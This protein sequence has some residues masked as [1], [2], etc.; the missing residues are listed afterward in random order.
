ML[1][2]LRVY[3]MLPSRFYKFLKSYEE[4]GFA[5]TTRYLGT[6]LGIFTSESGVQNR[7]FQFFVYENSAHRDR[8]RTAMLADPAWQPFV[9]LDA[10]ALLEQMNV[11]LHP[12][13]FTDL[14]APSSPR[15]RAASPRL[16]ELTTWTCRPGMR[17][18][19]LA[20]LEQ[21]GRQLLERHG[22][23]A[24]GYFTTDTGNEYQILRLAAFSSGEDRDRS[25]VARRADPE[26]RAF[27]ASFR[28]MLMNEDSTLLLPI[29]SSP[30][31]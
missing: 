6:T 4:V 27:L 8:C 7:T 1:I 12:A 5:L 20:L 25:N 18:S 15:E 17:D 29:K 9:K 11:L 22:S 30:L 21:G 14:A 2:D 28:S 13:P 19:A 31:Q 3:T 26:T 24:I 10:D 16:F 23:P